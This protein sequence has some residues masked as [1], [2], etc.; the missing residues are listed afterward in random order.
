M[1]CLDFLLQT[2]RIPAVSEGL[3]GRVE[4][5]CAGEISRGKLRGK[6]HFSLDHVSKLIYKLQYVY[7]IFQQIYSELSITI[8]DD[9]NLV[10]LIATTFP[11]CVLL[12]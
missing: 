2:E 11:P 9:Q 8:Q 7:N 6:R 1:I 5:L 10:T 4:S 12:G 3:L